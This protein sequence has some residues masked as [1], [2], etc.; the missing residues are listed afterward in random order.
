MNRFLLICLI[1]LFL[2]SCAT[3]NRGSTDY[4]RIDTVPQGAKATTSLETSAS[5]IAREKNKNIAPVYKGCEPTPCSIPLPRRSEFIITLEQDG[6]EN[7]EMY[8]TNSSNSGSFTANM[9]ATTVTSAGVTTAAAGSIAAVAT[10]VLTTSTVVVGGALGASA[11]IGTFGLI[12][13]Q[14]A[15]STGVSLGASS[16]PVTTTSSVLSAAVPPALLVTGGMLLTDVAT[17]A[18]VN[19]FPNPVVL[20]L[21][22]K[23]SPIKIDPNV[24]PFR[25]ILEIKEKRDYYCNSA[26]KFKPENQGKCQNLKIEYRQAVANKKAADKAAREKLKAEQKAAVLKN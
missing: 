24:A 10:G 5:L 12:P 23:G 15:I 2:S 14:T 9:A 6:Y 22:P 17:G 8:I 4:F 21:A 18:N 13:A 1:G 20:Q 25:N 11:S 7:A 3:V 16:A 19:L 26:Q